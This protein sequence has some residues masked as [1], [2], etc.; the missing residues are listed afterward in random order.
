MHE[1]YSFA[2]M[3]I[4]QQLFFAQQH[5]NKKI[6]ISLYDCYRAAAHKGTPPP[7]Q[8]L[9]DNRFSQERSMLQ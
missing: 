1:V 8:L 6:I 4:M 9:Y 2:S 7:A 5:Y 3:H